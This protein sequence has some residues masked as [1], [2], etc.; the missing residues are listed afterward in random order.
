VQRRAR[1]VPLLR[2]QVQLLAVDDR[3]AT[4][5]LHAAAG[6][7]QGRQPALARQPLP[8]LHQGGSVDAGERQRRRAVCARQVA[9]IVPPFPHISV[10]CPRRRRHVVRCCYSG[11]V[12]MLPMRGCLSR[13]LFAY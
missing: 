12:V 11:S 9:I 10:I 1:H 4:A 8:G 6:D 3:P 7:A 13:S 2:Q 5:V